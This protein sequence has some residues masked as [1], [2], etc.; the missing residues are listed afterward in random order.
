MTI[1]GFTAKSSIFGS[2]THYRNSLKHLSDN[3]Q[4]VNPCK[5]WKNHESP[6]ELPDS[7]RRTW[8]LLERACYNLYCE[9]C[10]NDCQRFINGLHDA[11]NIKLGKVMK[12]PDDFIYLRDF[13][14]EM[15]KYAFP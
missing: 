12:T 9:K 8:M 6:T 7:G 13:L 15:D 4:I 1:P 2:S 5:E 3:I 10:R 11:I 14:K